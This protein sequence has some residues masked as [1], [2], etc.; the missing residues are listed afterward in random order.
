MKLERLDSAAPLQRCSTAAHSGFCDQCYARASCRNDYDPLRGF[1]LF[2]KTLM[3]QRSQ[4]NALPTPYD[5]SDE[6]PA[7]KARR[8]NRIS[9]N[10]SA[11]ALSPA[12]FY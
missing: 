10:N 3:I 2:T 7:G 5:Q 11:A 8:R 4:L 9:C 12:S 6:E 1:G